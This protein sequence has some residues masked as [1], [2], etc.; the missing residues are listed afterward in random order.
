MSLHENAANGATSED[1]ANA[2]AAPGG[3]ATPCPYEGP[4]HLRAA[5][6][7]ALARVVDPEIA[8]SIVDLGLVYGVTMD[9]GA[10]HVTMTMTSAACPVTDLIVDEAWQELARVV[11][12]SIDLDIEVVWEPPWTPDRMSERGRRSMGWAA[13]AR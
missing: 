10:L 11:P 8:M 3:A 5:I 12:A 7:G 6:L 4:D 13:A 2:P 1:A 9:E